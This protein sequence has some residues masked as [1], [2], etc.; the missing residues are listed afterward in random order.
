MR[1]G[2]AN[3]Q[4]EAPYELSF[5]YVRTNTAA[6]PFGAY[7]IN[8]LNRSS[9]SADIAFSDLN[10]DLWS[11][12]VD[13]VLD[14]TDGITGTRRRRLRRHQPHQLAPRLPVRRA[15]DLRAGR[16]PVPARPAAPAE[17]DRLLRH[18]PDRGATRARPAFLAELENYAG[19]AKVNVEFAPGIS[20]DAGVRF[21]TATQTVSPI[22]VF[23]DPERLDRQH[24]A[25]ER[26]LAAGGD[27]DLGSHARAAVPAQRLEDDRPAAVPRADLPDRTSI[28]R[29]TASTS[30]TRCWSTASC[31][32]ARRGSNGTSRPSSA[33]RA[34]CSTRRSTTRSN[35]SSPSSAASSPPATPTRPRRSCI[36]VELEATKYF[37]LDGSCPTSRRLVL[38]AN[39]TY[40]K[41]ELKVA[42]GRS[43]GGVRLVV[44]HGDRLLPRR[45]AADRPVGPPGQPAGR[46]REPGPPVAADLPA[47]LRQRARGQPRPQRLAAA[48]RHP[49]GSRL[50]PRLRRARGVRRCSARRSKARSRS[51]TSSGASTRSSSNRATTGSRSTLTTSAR[52]SRGRSRSRS[53]RIA[54]PS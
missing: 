16:R 49:R 50:P 37:D 39:Y 38:V 41:S 47:D 34:R 7:F 48:A 13:L 35:R 8:R 52:R 33:S 54:H 44:D 43:G 11:G 26:L 1:G 5:E 42:A 3:S 23:T 53:E 14:I 27:A 12:G 15:A 25:Q 40:T 24:A 28:P 4:R 46:A 21:E 6:D 10:E 17:R 36:G 22:Q 2:Y 32:T 31:S 18:R 30:A 29:A 51:A 19:Y 20:L 45:L 9:G